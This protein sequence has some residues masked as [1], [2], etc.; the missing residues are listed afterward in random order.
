MQNNLKF[1]INNYYIVKNKKTVEPWI[2]QITEVNK[3]S[4]YCN[5]WIIHRGTEFDIQSAHYKLQF[6]YSLYGD[7]FENIQKIDIKDLKIIKL[8]YANT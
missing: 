4:L 1:E 7:Y 5:S 8:L 6:I 2:L 3:N